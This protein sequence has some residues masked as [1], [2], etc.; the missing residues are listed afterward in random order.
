MQTKLDTYIFQNNLDYLKQH[1]NVRN[2]NILRGKDDDTL[3]IMAVK[4]N[5]F[6]ITKW[7]LK[8][9][10][11][12]N[13][14]NRYSTTALM[15]ASQNN[16]FDIA[17]LLLSNGADP[18]ALSFE[19]NT[20]L[21]FAVDMN[22]SKIVE[23]LL[24]FNADVD[25]K[26][27]LGESAVLYC[28]NIDILKLLL[29]HRAD[30]NVKN[31]DGNTLLMLTV[32]TNDYKFTQNLLQYGA[33]PNIQNNNGDTALI[34]AAA[35]DIEYYSMVKL[36]LDHNADPSIQN[37]QGH[38][39][40]STAISYNNITISKL[41][42]GH[43]EDDEDWYSNFEH[44]IIRR[45]LDKIKKILRGVN[46]KE[47]PKKCLF[48]DLKIDELP[49]FD[50]LTME[51]YKIQDFTDE[52]NN[53]GALVFIIYN[54]R[55]KIYEA[56][57]T[58]IKYLDLDPSKYYVNCNNELDSIPT[59]KDVDIKTL[60]FKVFFQSLKSGLSFDVVNKIRRAHQ[61]S[62]AN[63]FVLDEEIKYTH[64]S[65]LDSIQ[66]YHEIN[67]FDEYLEYNNKAICQDGTDIYVYTSVHIPRFDGDDDDEICFKVSRDDLQQRKTHNLQ[68]YI[69]TEIS[70]FGE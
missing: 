4:H 60:F 69:T 12:P 11:L 54:K 19:N 70:I 43:N 3:L 67:I 17:K 66:L 63:I 15:I 18:N 5:K 25:I 61:T 29:A 52:T 14:A 40:Y 38:T 42:S 9:G 20:A 57:G 22:N 64:T 47:V 58:N 28:T 1:I 55:N 8:N 36:L 27:N 62:K 7:L 53:P 16:N 51:Y 44:A 41:L 37:Y 21:M 24:Y 45:K 6:N 49:V 68:H 56:W 32:D 2:I 13:L 23:L 33:N 46:Y 39:A 35:N 50:H 30:V 65:T 10:A 31:S 48:L 34:I 26:N 59:L